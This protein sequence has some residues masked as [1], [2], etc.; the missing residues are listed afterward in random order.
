VHETHITTEEIMGVY[1]FDGRALRHAGSFL[2]AGETP[3]SCLA[4]PASRPPRDD[5]PARLRG[6]DS[7]SRDM[8]SDRYDVPLGRCQPAARS[9]TTV[10]ARPSPA[11]AGVHC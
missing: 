1:T 5:R 6:T 11:Q 10:R 7:V 8:G 2:F 4:S 9:S 3:G